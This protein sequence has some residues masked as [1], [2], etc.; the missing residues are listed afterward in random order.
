MLPASFYEFCPLGVFGA[1]GKLFHNR[2]K[3]MSVDQGVEASLVVLPA[4]VYAPAQV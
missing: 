1:V 4:Q 2:P 3:G